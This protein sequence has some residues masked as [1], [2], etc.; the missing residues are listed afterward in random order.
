MY[1]INIITDPIL[2]DY[3]IN[4]IR[5]PLTLSSITGQMVKSILWG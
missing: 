2:D 4:D 1:K 5:Y 3:L